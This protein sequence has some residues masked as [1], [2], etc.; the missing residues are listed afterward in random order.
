MHENCTE[1]QSSCISSIILIQLPQMLLF[2]TLVSKAF[3]NGLGT[4]SLP[5][6]L[7]NSTSHLIAISYK[8][9]ILFTH[10]C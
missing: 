5:T 3:L 6:V 9:Q 1:Y 4:Y 7:S 2:K 10:F 8:F